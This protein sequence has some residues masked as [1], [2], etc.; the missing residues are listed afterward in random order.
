MDEYPGFAL[1]AAIHDQALDVTTI[2][3]VASNADGLV[4]QFTASATDLASYYGKQLTRTQFLI[5]AKYLS[6][7]PTPT[8]TPTLSK[9]EAQ[10]TL[11]QRAY[12]R[13]QTATSAAF[14]LSATQLAKTA[15]AQ[16]QVSSGGGG[17]VSGAVCPNAAYTCSQ[18]TCA[19]AYA[20]LAAGDSR[21]D[22]DHDGKPCE[23]QCGH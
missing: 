23:A 15:I 20:C 21:I 2:S 8:M 10:G 11:V 14:N 12:D 7:L 18:L 6:L 3:L 5:R 22:G 9:D 4:G 17:N 1:S 13:Q 19:Q 16:I